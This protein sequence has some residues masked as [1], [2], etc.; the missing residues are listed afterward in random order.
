[1]SGLYLAQRMEEALDH[2]WGS[3]V[4]RLLNQERGSITASGLY[5]LT[6]EK[7]LIDTA[8]ESL[9]AEDNKVLLVNDSYTPNFD[10]HDFRN[11]ITNE[12]SGTGY[13]AGGA[14]LTSTEV[15]LASGLLTF[16]AA[17]LSWA[18]ST[19]T[20]AMAG[21]LYFN[22]G[23]DTTDQLVLLSDFVTAASTTNGTFTIQWSASGIATVDYT[24]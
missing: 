24:P 20:S 18:S 10:T 1:M 21:V 19:I 12:V 17:D 4:K 7:M 6:L 22:V 11:D 5:G 8:G 15:T 14:A 2:E 13:T 23:A 3:L 9:E 16:D